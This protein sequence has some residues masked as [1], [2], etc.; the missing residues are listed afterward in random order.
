MRK[1]GTL[2]L[3]LV[4]GGCVEVV[5]FQWIAQGIQSTG[6]AG[7]AGGQGGAGGV[8]FCSPGEKRECYTGPTETKGKGICAAGEET[9]NAQGTAFGACE[10]EMLP[11]PEDC[12]TPVDDDC[13]GI[14][15]PCKGHLLWAKQFGPIDPSPTAYAELT[16]MASDNAANVILTGQFFET[17]GFDE[18]A[19]TSAGHL[20]VFL[21][22]LDSTGALIW[23]KR[24][25][26]GAAQRS[27]SVAVGPD[28]SV[29]VTGQFFGTMDLGGAPLT[30]A[31]KTDVFVGKVDSQGVHQWSKSFG[32]GESQEGLRVA[33]DSQGAVIV[34]GSLRGSADFGGGQLVSAGNKDVFLAKLD[35]AGAHQWSKRFG[36]GAPQDATGLAVAADGSLFLVGQFHGTID[37]GGGPLVSQGSTD[38]FVA[39]LAPDGTHLWSMRHGDPQ[40]QEATSVALPIDANAPIVVVGSF[41]GAVDLG[42]K[43]L[44]SAGNYDVF[45]AQLDAAGAT[46]WASRFGDAEYQ[47]ADGAT[48]DSLQNVILAGS[49]AGSIDFGGGP[50]ASAGSNDAFVAKL[51]AR[52]GHQWSKRFGSSAGQFIKGV[53]SDKSNAVLVGG[54]F[55]GSIDFGGGPFVASSATSDLFVAKFSD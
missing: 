12:A 7:G 45:V 22:K 50:L 21:S 20:D 29:A 39:K 32:D 25:G 40:A 46:Q 13:D 19:L 27:A 26:D 9:C 41:I 3:V 24:F 2:A 1:I 14:A 52:G 38:I 18:V 15:P 23:A 47:G 4:A 48:V 6:G 49:F 30:S 31:G 5:D 37:F 51:D 8:P 34:A 11:H 10:G 43:L 54:H 44:E 17:I 35:S 33:V 16:S 53:T 55:A 36:D 42:A 28:D